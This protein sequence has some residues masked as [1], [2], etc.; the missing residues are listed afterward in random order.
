MIARSPRS[1]APSN[2]SVM[3]VDL[4][5]PV[6]PMNLKCLVSSARPMAI[7]ARCNEVSLLQNFMF[8][9]ALR[10]RQPDTTKVPRLYHSMAS[11]SSDDQIVGLLSVGRRLAIDTD[12]QARP[13][14]TAPQ[15][16]PSA[17]LFQA[18]DFCRK[19]I[20]P[21]TERCYF[22]TRWNHPTRQEQR[23]SGAQCGYTH[24]PYENPDARRALDLA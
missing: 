16:N 21:G 9:N 14:T 8:R 22:S 23:N 13:G 4:P 19:L 6:V 15:I 12:A 20:V 18:R 2:S 5:V 1:S 10:A 17:P 24:T 7:P 11:I 3:A